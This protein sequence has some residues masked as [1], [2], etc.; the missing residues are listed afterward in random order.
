MCHIPVD[1]DSTMKPK[2]ST[3]SLYP[4]QVEIQ[5]ALFP[6]RSLL[7][8]ESQLFSFPAST[9]MFQFPAYSCL[10]ACSLRSALSYSEILGSMPACGSPKLIAACHVLRRHPSQAIPLRV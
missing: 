6:F 10:S 7:M 5:F 9:K 8:G 2:C 4:F 3:T 1:L